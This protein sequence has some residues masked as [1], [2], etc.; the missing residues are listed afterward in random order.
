MSATPRPDCYSNLEYLGAASAYTEDVYDAIS[1]GPLFG[2]FAYNEIEALCKFLHCFA[3]PRGV[4]L[5][6]EGD[7]EDY[8]IVILSGQV[9]VSKL[10]HDGVQVSLATVFPGASLGEMSLVDG[11]ERFAS[12]VTACPTDFAVL[13]RADLNEFLV[14]YPWLANKLLIRLM[15]IMAERLRITGSLFVENYHCLAPRALDMSA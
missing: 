9:E 4:T 7:E 2:Q 1:Q 6:A 10:N 8:V 12:C 13:T 5:L 3:A 11:K 14:A 15:Q